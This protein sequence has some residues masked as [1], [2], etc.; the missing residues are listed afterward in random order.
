MRWGVNSEV[1][2]QENI[3]TEVTESSNHVLSR[4]HS[5]HTAAGRAGIIALL[6]D[7]H[8]AQPKNESLLHNTKIAHTHTVCKRL[9]TKF[10]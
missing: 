4:T 2:E 10:L 6:D 5:T 7:M 3:L 9:K 8:V 1:L